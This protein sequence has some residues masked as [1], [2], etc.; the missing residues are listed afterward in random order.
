MEREGMPIMKLTKRAVDRIGPVTRPTYYFD[1]DLP[2]FFLRVMPPGS[3]AWGLEY[4]AGTGR[5]A[6]KRRVTIAAFGKLTPEEARAPAKRLAGDVAKGGD[7]ASTKATKS[8]EMTVA[9]L[10]DLYEAEG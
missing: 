1:A 3:R 10:V 4:R 2:G 5:S 7:P 9:G 6:P 8:R